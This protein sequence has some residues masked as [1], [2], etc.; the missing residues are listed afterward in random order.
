MERPQVVVR[1]L[2]QRP[3]MTEMGIVDALAKIGVKTSQPTINRLRRGKVGRAS[4][5]LAVGLNR[6]HEQITGPVS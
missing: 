1:R 6:L 3:D 5:D 2:L 4:F